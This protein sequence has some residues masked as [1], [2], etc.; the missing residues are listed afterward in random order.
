MAEHRA[1]PDWQI[2]FGHWPY[3]AV[4]AHRGAGLLA[5]E[6][7]LAAM[8]VGA[9]HGHRFF[10]FD[11]KLSGDGKPFLL[12]DATLDRTTDGKGPAGAATWAELAQL[13][14]GSWHGPGFA[15]EPLP[16]LRAV[17]AFLRANGLLANVEIKPGPGREAETGAAVAVAVAHA[18]RD[19]A[20]PPLLSSFSET[21]LE[22]AARAVPG[23][24]RALLTERIAQD[25]LARIRRLD[26]VAL[27][28]HHVALSAE[29][30]AEAHAAG[31]RVLT[32][33]VN[34]PVRAAVLRDWGVDCVI[35]DAIDLI[36]P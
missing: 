7:T 8:R 2:R 6:N 16:S 15:G 21:A 3:P 33:T 29:A 34:D 11:V 20:I 31:V 12:H 1:L 30:V 23:L 9:A 17:A 25:W 36:R 5:P 14:A 35:T 13:D 10:E 27:D 18:W 22:A 24:P 28:V 4:A 32:Y 26:A 19:A